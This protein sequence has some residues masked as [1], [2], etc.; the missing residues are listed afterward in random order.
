M[1]TSDEQVLVVETRFYLLRKKGE[2]TPK[3]PKDDDL[4]SLLKRRLSSLLFI[5]NLKILLI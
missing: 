5:F 2:F 1:E 3:I 4:N